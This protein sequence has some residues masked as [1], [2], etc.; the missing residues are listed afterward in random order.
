MKLKS[1]FVV[2][3]GLLL[4]LPVSAQRQ[5]VSENYN[6]PT[7]LP[8][9]GKRT[10]SYII[11]EDGKN[12]KDGSFSITA[13][14]EAL[15]YRKG[16]VSY[17]LSSNGHYKVNTTFRKGLLNGA[18]NFSYNITATA[19]DMRGGSQTDKM[20]VN[21]IGNFADGLP[22][23]SFN[24]V[25][26][27]EYTIKL[28]AQYNRGVLV[29]AYSC[30]CIEDGLPVIANGTLSSTGDLVGKWT[31]QDINGHTTYEFQNGVLVLKSNDRNGSTKPSV[32][33]WA[34]KYA[35]GTITEEE[36]FEHNILVLESSISLGSYA[37]QVALWHDEVLDFESIGGYDFS[38]PNDKTYKYLEEV[39]CFNDK[40]FDF[41][42]QKLDEQLEKGEYSSYIGGNSSK[43]GIISSSNG[44]IVVED[45]YLEVCTPYIKAVGNEHP[46][47]TRIYLTKEQ[48]RIWEEKI[49][50]Y[51][52]LHALDFSIYAFDD[53]VAYYIE[54]PESS[55][56][57]W[58]YKEIHKNAVKEIEGGGI[59]TALDDLILVPGESDYFIEKD[60]FGRE[61]DPFWGVSF[62]KKES[63]ERDTMMLYILAG[64]YE[65]LI[66]T[67]SENDRSKIE[68]VKDT[69]LNKFKHDMEMTI[70]NHRALANYAAINDYIAQKDNAAFSYDQYLELEEAAQSF[71]RKKDFVQLD[72]S[73]EFYLLD[74]Q[75]V[76]KRE[77]IELI[78]VI[79]GAHEE[80]IKDMSA[81]E[82]D[83]SK[84]EEMRANYVRKS[85]EDV[86]A[87]FKPLF[88][89]LLNQK[90]AVSLANSED[91][92]KY[93][94]FGT[95]ENQDLAKRLKPFFPIQDYE[96]IGVSNY[97]YGSEFHYIDI[98]CYIIKQTK[99]K[100]IKYKVTWMIEKD[101]RGDERILKNSIDINSA[102]I[103]SEEKLKT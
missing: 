72:F 98:E 28:K 51:K 69:F 59:K 1:F 94:S 64:K 11:G 91:A 79:A 43:L 74:G 67:V 7:G 41:Y 80:L 52:K 99:R 49:H 58:Q 92:A 97:H 34:K 68:K 26:G 71:I 54:E 37:K 77:V 45:A 62:I 86:K 101:R 35:A 5:Q 60:G 66:A 78:Y 87:Q 32:T 2:T 18:F 25:Y 20:T 39:T 3:I 76:I 23:G 103:I 6:P 96:I 102:T 100:T 19:Q 85:K 82:N 8:M 90:D 53:N 14:P 47:D 75:N 57:Y 88:D 30:T 31:I 21:Y 27:T 42:T 15:T 83:R 93:F 44:C 89:I 9:P 33:E 55:F 95:Y 29:G 61:Y 63:I 4:G 12:L 36:L 17:K 70:D 22:H 24:I 16:Y 65:E 48:A 10:Y 56:A 84:I 40:G 50:E 73:P 38:E 81:C 13:K 46:W